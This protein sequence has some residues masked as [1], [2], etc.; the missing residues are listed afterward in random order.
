MSLF[1][2]GM[3]GGQKSAGAR[4]L[5]GV[6]DAKRLRRAA[7]QFGQILAV[8]S[9]RDPHTAPAKAI[10][11]ASRLFLPALILFIALLS[12]LVYGSAPAPWFGSFG[13]EGNTL[14]TGVLELPL[15]LFI[16]HLTNRRYGAAYAMA[17]VLCA[18]ALLAF[19]AIVFGDRIE[20]LRGGALPN[21]R[22]LV[23]FGIGHFAAQLS[24]LVI[25]D[26]LRGSHWWQAPFFG[27]M[28][29]GAALALIAFPVAYAGT[30]V[31]WAD[32]MTAFAYFAVSA[33]ALMLL[34]YRLIRTLIAPLPGLGGC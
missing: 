3:P 17:Q 14:E 13:V 18:T 9:I 34:P 12:M 8:D 24:S 22:V 29:G 32:A 20:M 6:A 5:S 4:F 28:V 33:A 15:A 31:D 7:H 1:V 27:S 19:T 10:V 30:D 23:G 25:F 11:I 2:P 26:R 16:V 21:A